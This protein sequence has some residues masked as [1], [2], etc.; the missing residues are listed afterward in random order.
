MRLCWEAALLPG[1]CAGSAGSAGLGRHPFTGS[2]Q[3][4]LEGTS[5][6]PFPALVSFL[7]PKGVFT[8][9]APLGSALVLLPMVEIPHLTHI[10]THIL[11]PWCISERASIQERRVQT[12]VNSAATLGF[13][14]ALPSFFETRRSRQNTA[15]EKKQILF[16][17]SSQDRTRHAV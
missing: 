16:D 2:E 17:L 7:H 6:G 1:S 15:A 13:I 3:F 10:Q 5:E 8:P 14:T 9:P 11:M 12:T 4:G